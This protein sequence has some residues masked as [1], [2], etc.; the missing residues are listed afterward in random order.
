MTDFICG[1]D[2]VGLG[3][4]CGPIL[5]CAVLAPSDWRVEGL[6]DSKTLKKG[7]SLK[8]LETVYERI[9]SCAPF[10]QW[11]LE[12]ASNEEIDRT[13]LYRA[14]HRAFRVVVLAAREVQPDAKV[15][16]DGNVRLKGI[17]HDSF[18]KADATVPAVMAASVIAKL[19]R[20]RWMINEADRQYPQYMLRN[21]VGYATAEHLKALD[22]YGPC[23][24]HRMSY[25]PVFT[26]A[27][28]VANE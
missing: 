13:S 28:V 4:L 27:G 22:E 11:W 23:P 25:E 15:I 12:W 6:A 21:H 17:E 2:E 19:T 8:K 3:S 20:D 10:V 18:P 1:A 5:C 16:I 7:R 9:V 26:R 14:Q 24:L